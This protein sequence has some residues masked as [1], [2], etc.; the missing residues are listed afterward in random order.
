[1]DQWTKC[2]EWASPCTL[3]LCDESYKLIKESLVKYS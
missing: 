1:M 2:A 3:D